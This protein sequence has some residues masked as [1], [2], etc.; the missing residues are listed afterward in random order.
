MDLVTTKF[1][2]TSKSC[3]ENSQHVNIPNKNP[4]VVGIYAPQKIPRKSQT[5]C[6]TYSPR[7]TGHGIDKLFRTKE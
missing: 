2:I 6:T 5:T 3:S 4:K 7:D 1:S